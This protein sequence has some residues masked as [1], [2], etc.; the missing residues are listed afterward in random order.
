MRA[1]FC[2][3]IKRPGSQ[4][5]A[6][7]RSFLCS[8]DAELREILWFVRWR[9]LNINSSLSPNRT[10]VW[11]SKEAFLFPFAQQANKD[12]FKCIVGIWTFLQFNITQ[13]P[14]FIEN[15]AKIEN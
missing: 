9:E 2:T 6:W 7:W 10:N 4:S 11:K 5:P 8:E 3:F 14:K 13:I 1:A 12:M 15:K